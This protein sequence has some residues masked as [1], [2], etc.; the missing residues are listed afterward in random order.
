LAAGIWEGRRRQA[1][2]LVGRVAVV[3]GGASGIGFALAE[4]FAAEGM[5]VVVADVEDRA[6]A[7]AAQRLRSV[8]AE[9]VPIHC[10]VARA[11]EVE[12][13]ATARW[14]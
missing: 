9:V 2:E 14:A 10:D 1:Q 8:A 4:R 11:D 13:L 6:L 7:E 3:T 5:K 12:R